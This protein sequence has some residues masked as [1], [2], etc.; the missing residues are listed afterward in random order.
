M[1]R[2][3]QDLAA[4]TL[5]AVDTAPFIYFWEHHSRYFHLS[6]QLFQYLNNPQAQGVTSVI[7]LIEACILPQREGRQ[8]LVHAYERAL[9]Y[10]QQIHTLPIHAAVAR[11]AIVLRAQHNIHVPDALQIATGI[12]AG[13]SLFVTNDRRLTSVQGIETTTLSETAV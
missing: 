6:E 9:L 2:L 3:D 13:A 4:H 8:D 1:R 5:I 7:T 10:S 11:Q 12:E